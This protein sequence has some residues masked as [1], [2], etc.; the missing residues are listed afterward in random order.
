MY[1]TQYKPGQFAY[2]KGSEPRS[3]P[4]GEMTQNAGCDKKDPS[5]NSWNYIDVMKKLDKQI[6]N[7]SIEIQIG[8]KIYIFKNPYRQSAE[9]LQ[10]KLAQKIY[11]SIRECDRDV[12]DIA[13]NLGFKA[14][15]IKNVKARVFYNQHYLD[16][17][18]PYQIDYKRFDA[19]LEQALSW[20][21][22]QTGTYT[23]EDITW[24]EHECAERH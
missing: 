10:F 5:R 4:V 22:L 11:D 23:P 9:E 6:I 24:I 20:K 21:H 7:P 19:T 13:Q 12:C 8:D 1:G 18:G 3:S 14:K 17:H 16:R 15:N 2:G